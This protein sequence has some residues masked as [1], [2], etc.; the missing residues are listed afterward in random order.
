MKNVVASM[1]SEAEHGA[2]AACVAEAERDTSAEIAI[3]LADHSSDYG[4]A[5]TAGA[6][7]LSLFAAALLALILG[8]DSMWL[9]LL[10]FALLYPGARFLLG[11]F[12][13]LKRLFITDA[14]SDEEVMEAAT[15]AFYEHGLSLTRERNAILVYFSAFERRVRIVAD[16]GMA[17]KE[18]QATWDSVASEL[19]ATMRQ[20]RVSQGLCAAVRRLGGLAAAHY[21]P[22]PDDSDELQNVIIGSPK[23][24]EF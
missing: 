13:G 21:P 3:V 22:R 8:W 19:A 7:S 17:A 6:M 24:N 15:V 1:L 5:S 2:V 4:R 23:A 18:K 9:F 20:G 14:E 11:R 10:L 16:T 12:P